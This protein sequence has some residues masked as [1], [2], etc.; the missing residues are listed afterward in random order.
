MSL[1]KNITPH[2]GI[3]Y[4]LQDDFFLEMEDGYKYRL[5]WTG[6]LAPILGLRGRVKPNEWEAALNGYFSGKAKIKG[7]SLRDEK[8]NLIHRSGTDFEMSAPKSLSIQALVFGDERLIM[9]HYKAMIQAVKVFEKYVGCRRGHGGKIWETTGLGLIAVVTHFV[10]REGDPHVHS[11]VIFL[12]ITMNSDGRFC[13]MSNDLMIHYQRLVQ[14]IYHLELAKN[15]LHLGYQ[16]EPGVFQEPQIVGYTR[17]VIEEFS[18]RGKKILEYIKTKFRIDWENLTPVERKHRFWLHDEAWRKTRKPKLIRDVKSLLLNWQER[19]L[20]VGAEKVLSKGNEFP[21]NLNRSIVAREALMGSL[22]QLFAENTRVHEGEVLRTAMQLARGKIGYADLEKVYL[23]ELQTGHL[24][25]SASQPGSPNFLMTEA[26]MKKEKSAHG[27]MREGEE[28]NCDKHISAQ[29]NTPLRSLNEEQLDIDKLLRKLKKKCIELGDD[30]LIDK[31]ELIIM[32]LIE[33]M[34]D[35]F[36]VACSSNLSSLRHD[37][38][39]AMQIHIPRE[40]TIE[41]SI[42]VRE[43]LIPEERNTFSTY[44]VGRQ[45][46]FL[47]SN[48]DLEI[49]KGE[50]AKITYNDPV[51]GRIVM[52]TATKTFE[53]NLLSLLSEEWELGRTTKIKLKPGDRIEI[54]GDFL[55]NVG[56]SRGQ[57]GKVVKATKEAL[58]IL[59]EKE[60]K[61]VIVTVGQAPLEIDHGY[62]LSCQSPNCNFK[63]KFI[64]LDLE[65]YD[66]FIHPDNLKFF[67]NLL[68]ARTTIITMTDN[69]TLLARALKRKLRKQPT[70]DLE[71][72]Q[73]KEKLIERVDDHQLGLELGWE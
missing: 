36:I 38:R 22:E 21:S 5:V 18:G 47:K 48:P 61:T 50:I 52:S 13:A 39:E 24:L 43:S 17:D 62:V 32:E 8:G 26:S 65:S 35:I 41:Y 30:F 54:T 31:E 19:A 11:H 70:L 33:R 57:L 25:S 4:Y 37:V 23:Q 7:G 15:I 67:Q 6:K 16:V 3:K 64:I 60:D 27:L 44:R 66:S 58:E 1:G 20:G 29:K 71:K 46:Q 59:C 56:I 40:G 28:I 2:Q 73:E 55:S 63:A 53:T 45:I 10:N 72:S 14:E 42:F 9:A 34:P 69:W 51:N 49:E 12:N 68:K